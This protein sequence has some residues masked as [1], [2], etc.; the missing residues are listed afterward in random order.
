MLNAL[1]IPTLWILGL[2][3]DVIPVYPSLARLEKLIKKGKTKNYVHVFPFGDHNFSNTSTGD[4]Y[5]VG[6]V[7]ETWLKKIG[8]L[9]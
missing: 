4:R 7:S 3:D 8:I 6:A 9:H 5:D 1:D 2:R